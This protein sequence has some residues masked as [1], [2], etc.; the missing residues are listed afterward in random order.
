[1]ASIGA[2]QLPPGRAPNRSAFNQNGP[3]VPAVMRLISSG[4]T[5][6]FCSNL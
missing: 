4:P 3:G 2:L 1:V 5:G 6:K